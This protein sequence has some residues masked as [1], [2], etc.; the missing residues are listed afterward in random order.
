MLQLRQG[1]QIDDHGEGVVEIGSVDIGGTSETQIDSVACL[2]VDNFGNQSHSV[3]Q[4]TCV[5][6]HFVGSIL[7][8]HDLDQV[9]VVQF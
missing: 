3:E 7:V 5:H 4:G 6:H 8:T 2:I 9:V 1:S